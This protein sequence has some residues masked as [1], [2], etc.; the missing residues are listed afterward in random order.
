MESDR[1]NPHEELGYVDPRE[2]EK[3]RAAHEVGLDPETATWPEIAQANLAKHRPAA[4]KPSSPP[5]EHSDGPHIPPTTT[6]EQSDDETA[7]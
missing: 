5:G 6:P 3:A 4:P 2:I 7:A 1:P